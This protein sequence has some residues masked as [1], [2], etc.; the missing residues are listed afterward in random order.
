DEFTPVYT[1]KTNVQAMDSED[2]SAGYKI[3]S[4]A[5]L[6]KCKTFTY[7]QTDNRYEIPTGTTYYTEKNT[8]DAINDYVYGSIYLNGLKDKDG[9]TVKAEFEKVN[10]KEWVTFYFYIATGSENQ[11]VN[12]DLWLGANS[13]DRTSTGVVFFDDCHVYRYSA[14]KFWSLYKDNLGLS[15]TQK[16]TYT[17]NDGK[18]T[19]TENFD[20]SCEQLIDLRQE[21]K[22]AFNGT[23]FDFENSG[24]NIDKI[25]NWEVKTNNGHAQ[26][27]NTNA[28][29]LFVD[30]YQSVGSDFSCDVNFN[31]D[32][33][34][35]ISGLKINP[36][37]YALTLWANNG[38]ASVK[39][40]SVRIR[41]NEI[42]KVTA[43]Y[44]I[45]EIKSGNAYMSIKENDKVLKDYNL[46]LYTLT[47]KDSSSL[48]S[49]GTNNFNNK[50]ATVEFYV[51]GGA[52]YNTNFNIVLS[53][54]KDTEKAI[55]VFH[56]TTSKLKKA[57]QKT[58]ITLQ[59]QLNLV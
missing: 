44:K 5:S 6:F 29:E 57:Q 32:T 37:Q 48:S 54:G 53:L 2:T 18:V 47:D 42:Y 13:Q 39:S 49:N 40:E 16:V 27:F 25:N 45:S 43:S 50:Y 26:V 4:G 3:L 46:K 12:L 11:S 52:L 24:T 58:L 20:Q 31:Y 30:N 36:N 17:D 7:N 22:L 59:I 23:N 51:K 38:M 56:L 21:E 28:P 10:S 8:Y 9:K 35:N 55:V 19:G 33:N 34:G 41:A 15:Y 14:N 1:L